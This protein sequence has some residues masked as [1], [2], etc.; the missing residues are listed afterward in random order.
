MTSPS[1]RTA[2][3]R[4]ARHE[5]AALPVDRGVLLDRI[6]KGDLEMGWNDL[7]HRERQRNLVAKTL[8]WGVLGGTKDVDLWFVGPDCGSCG[9]GG[10]RVWGGNEQEFGL[11]G[12]ADDERCKDEEGQGRAHINS[13]WFKRA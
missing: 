3:A 9:V 11:R 13:V 12:S 6:G 8:K 1:G 7:A 10:T 5:F 4:V 2:L